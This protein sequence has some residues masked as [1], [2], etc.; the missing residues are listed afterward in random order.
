MLPI[1]DNYQ[2][3]N[4]IVAIRK[5]DPEAIS[6]LYDQYS[7][8]LFGFIT[9]MVGNSLIAEGVLQNSFIVIWKSLATYDPEKERL[10]T[11]MLKITTGVCI[12]ALPETGTIDKADTGI[13]DYEY[14]NNAISLVFFKGLSLEDAAKKL[15]VP[16]D[17]LIPK[18]KM[19]FKQL[20]GGLSL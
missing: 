10:L 2:G 18:M 19:A 15:E 11:W 20:H 13:S 3:H 8:I 1:K 4:I 6:K 5:G 14:L 7:G 16:L 9:R 12:D 17:V